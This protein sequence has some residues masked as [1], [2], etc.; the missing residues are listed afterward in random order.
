MARTI[1][2]QCDCGTIQEVLAHSYKTRKHKDKCNKCI[3]G[4]VRESQLRIKT[5][6]PLEYERRRECCRLGG[7]NR[8]KNLTSEQKS[9]HGKKMRSSV[10]ITGAEMR[11]RQQEYINNAGPE[12]QEQYRKSRSRGGIKLHSSMTNAEREIHFRK[13]FKNRGRS[14]ASDECLECISSEL[15]IVLEYEKMVSGFIAD[16]IISETNTLI[17]FYGDM[18]HCNPVKFKDPTKYCSWISRTVQQQWDRDRKRLGVFYKNG[19]KVIVIWE[20]DWNTN[21]QLVLERIKNEV[22]EC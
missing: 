2:I 18:F 9:E 19:Y 4:I 14:K 12:Y 11:Q 15:G 1:Q 10:T 16:A 5:D 6:N 8:A 7:I 22:R 20:S 3:R 21:R 13:V 17:E